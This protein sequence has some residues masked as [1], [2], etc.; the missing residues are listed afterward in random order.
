MYLS[1]M[2][3]WLAAL[4]FTSSRG[5]LNTTSVVISRWA[6]I[7]SD[8]SHELWTGLLEANPRRCVRRPDQYSV[9]GVAN[10]K[11]RKTV[12]NSPDRVA[13]PFGFASRCLRMSV[14]FLLSVDQPRSRRFPEFG[15]ERDRSVTAFDG[16]GFDA[17]RAIANAMRMAVEDS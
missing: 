3:L 14:E 1:R 4:K 10:D 2:A 11:W 7:A 15:E 17:I 8:R 12:F 16:T 5:F 13:L 6:S 9:S